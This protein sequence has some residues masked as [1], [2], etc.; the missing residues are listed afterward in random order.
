MKKIYFV[1]THT[2]S[3]LSNCVKFYTK[4]NYSHVSISLDENLNNMYSFGRR[5]AYN[6]FYGGFVQ[7]SPRYG[8]FKRFKKTNA[9]IY[10]LEVSDKDYEKIKDIISK[11]DKN[12]NIY[13]FNMIGLIAVILN[14]NVKRRHHFYCA[15]F[16]KYV[17]DN[18][19]LDIDLPSITKP[20]D[21]QYINGS[22]CEYTGRLRDYKV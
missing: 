18:T 4:T 5:H 20:E 12:K 16:V 21:F 8:T 17:L 13:R 15:Q 19:D 14:L 2:G 11:F 7:E 3:L 10:S 9:K 6:P 1:L 22:L